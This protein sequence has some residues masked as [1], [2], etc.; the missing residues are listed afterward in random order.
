MYC[1]HDMT[2]CSF[3]ITC[4]QGDT[5]LRA[6]TEKINDESRKLKIPI[7]QYMEVPK[8]YEYNNRKRLRSELVGAGYDIDSV[9]D[10]SMNL[11]DNIE[12]ILIQDKEKD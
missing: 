8:C 1:L 2:Y 10:K 9:Y 4:K 5:C 12:K 3:Y 6:L 11:L 7:C